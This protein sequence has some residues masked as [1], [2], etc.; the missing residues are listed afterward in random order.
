VD[1]LF[2]ILAQRDLPRTMDALERTFTAA[3]AKRVRRP[4]QSK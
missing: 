3:Q 1:C 2:V 4:R